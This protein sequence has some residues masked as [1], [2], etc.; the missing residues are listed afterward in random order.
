VS[1]FGYS[2]VSGS[3]VP[4][5]TSVVSPSQAHTLVT[6]QEIG[7]EPGLTAVQSVVTVDRSGAVLGPARLF[8]MNPP[9]NTARHNYTGFP[10]YN[11]GTSDR[12]FASGM[13][14]ISIRR[15]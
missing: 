4:L 2:S 11:G 3:T 5:L 12:L 10:L 6:Y 9:P 15:C 1:S 7:Y 14:R 8:S 13:R